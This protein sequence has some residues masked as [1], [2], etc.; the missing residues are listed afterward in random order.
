VEGAEFLARFEE[1]HSHASTHLVQL[2]GA[3]VVPLVRAARTLVV[4]DDEASSGETFLNAIEAVSSALTEIAAAQTCCITDWSSGAYCDRARVPTATSSLLSG[5]LAWTS[6]P[7]F[8]TPALAPA[9]N[10]PGFAPATGMR[11]RTGLLEPERALRNPITAR[12]GERVLVLGDGE[13]GFE[14]L[15]A[16][17]DVEAAGGIAA[18]QCISRSPA[19]LGHAVESISS[20]SDSYGSGAP[21]FLY[22]LLGH[23][24]DRILILAEA[25]GIQEEDARR[26]LSALETELPVDRLLCT[27]RDN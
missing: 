20:F 14:A 5:R 25:D 7:E 24:P 11:S 21:C 22:N 23:R 1:A 6:D 19:L 4:V 16:A 12:L 26:A 8:E 15:L 13:H 10:R 2:E 27:Y 18:V 9:T 17:E 3:E